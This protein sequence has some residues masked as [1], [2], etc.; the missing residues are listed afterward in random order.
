ML[1]IPHT[2][3]SWTLARWCGWPTG[4]D[5]A[6]FRPIR[7]PCPGGWE[8]CSHTTSSSSLRDSR[9]QGADMSF[10]RDVAIVGGCGHVGL[11]LGLAF[12]DR[13][14]SVAL[15]DIDEEAVREVA[16]GKMPFAEPGAQRI[17]ERV[18]GQNLEV[19]SDPHVLR[20]AEA[21]VVVIGTPLDEHLN[22]DPSAVPRVIEA[23]K[24][25][26]VDGQLLVLRSTT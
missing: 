13:G 1:Q 5:F 21:V 15:Y 25:D 20:T 23:L 19:T 22:P 4:Q 6:W 12:A 17:L 2:S 24:D 9:A 26:L 16:E 11:P 14:L 7:S 3:S 10:T 18:I 8:R